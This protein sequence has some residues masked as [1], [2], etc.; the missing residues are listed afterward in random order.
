MQNESRASLNTVGTI[1]GYKSKARVLP[2]LLETDF[3]LYCPQWRWCFLETRFVKENCYK[4]AKNWLSV[5]DNNLR[6]LLIA[7]KGKSHEGWGRECTVQRAPQGNQSCDFSDTL[8]QKGQGRDE[9]HT[10]ECFNCLKGRRQLTCSF[11]W[12]E[13]LQ[14][15]EFFLS[16]QGHL[17]PGPW[18]A[19]SLPHTPREGDP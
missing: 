16:E 10:C 15:R 1:L 2:A 11:R 3:P 5:V 4:L 18:M 17:S 8:L 6:L 9:S 12:R 13:I 19:V 14:R 7:R